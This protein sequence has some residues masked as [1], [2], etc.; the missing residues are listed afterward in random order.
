MFLMVPESG[1]GRVL[2]KLKMKHENGFGCSMAPKGG[3]DRVWEG[4]K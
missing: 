3:V 4:S 2:G 1:V